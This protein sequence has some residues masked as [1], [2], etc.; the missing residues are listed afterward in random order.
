MVW[1]RM[2]PFLKQI[3]RFLE[4]SLESQE[5]VE[6]RVLSQWTCLLLSWIPDILV[7]VKQRPDIQRLPPP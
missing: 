3:L 7:C 1:V 2:L 5:L 4:Q 6:A